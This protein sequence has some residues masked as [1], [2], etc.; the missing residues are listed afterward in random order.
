MT[1]DAFEYSTE[2]AR[3]VELYQFTIGSTIYRYTSAEDQVSFSSQTW[4]PRQISRNNPDQSS[5]DRRQQIEVIL[6]SSDTLARRFIAIP[7]GPNVQLVV[8]RFHRSDAEA[9]ILWQGNIISA[10]YSN[11]NTIC[12]LVGVTSEAAFDRPVPRFKYQGLCNHVLFDGGCG[13]DRES[14]KYTG[15]CTAVSGNT[16]TVSGLLASEG[17]GWAVGGYVNFGDQDYRL[18]VSQSGDVLTLLVPFE[19]SPLNQSVEVFAGCDHTLATCNSKF[20][21]VVNYGGF[22][23]VPT[24]NPFSSGLD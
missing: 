8:T 13:L 6:P 7:P 24:L 17:A 10:G 16:I 21:N 23:Y 20:S 22:P 14:F 4:F 9:V 2:S 3:P 15:T 12:T 1:F 5:E 11:D 19:T 18:V